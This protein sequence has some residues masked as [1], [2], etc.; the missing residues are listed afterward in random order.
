MHLSKITF[1][2][3]L[4]AAFF[5]GCL[6]NCSCEVS[7]DKPRGNDTVIVVPSDKQKEAAELY[8]KVYKD[9]T[10]RGRGSYAKQ[11]AKEAVLT[12]YGTRR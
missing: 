1:G 6:T 10:D 12:I 3:A 5:I 2:F 4:F 11:D 9:A 8:A 7:K